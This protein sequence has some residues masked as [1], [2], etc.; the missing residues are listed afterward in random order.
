MTGFH[1]IAGS[2]S[3]EIDFSQDWDPAILRNPVK[4]SRANIFSSRDPAILQD[5]RGLGTALK[6]IFYSFPF[7]A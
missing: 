6:N 4:N 2:K 3:C 7:K 1:R 5:L